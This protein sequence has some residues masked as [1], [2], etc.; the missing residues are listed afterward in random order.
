MSNP[1]VSHG[2]ACP[3]CRQTDFLRVIETRPTD[4]GVK[5]RRLCEYCGHRFTTLEKPRDAE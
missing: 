3:S 1:G 4:G 2:L 5:R